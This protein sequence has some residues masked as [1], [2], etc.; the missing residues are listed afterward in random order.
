MADGVWGGVG[1]FLSG[2]GVSAL[3]L[4]NGWGQKQIAGLSLLFNVF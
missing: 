1:A 2:G 4:Q 3:G